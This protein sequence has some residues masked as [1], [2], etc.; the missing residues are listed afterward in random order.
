MMIFLRDMGHWY[1]PPNNCFLEISN[2]FNVYMI[3]FLLGHLV[4]TPQKNPPAIEGAPAQT[5]ATADTLSGTCTFG[6]FGRL[7]LAHFFDAE[8]LDGNRG[9]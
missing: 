7:R 3:P 2:H 6:T 4:Q 8:E 1:K 9:C 5:G